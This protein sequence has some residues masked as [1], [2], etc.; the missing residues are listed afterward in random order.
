MT[1]V[2]W[3]GL[4]WGIA[5]VVVLVFYWQASLHDRRRRT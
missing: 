2:Q 4:I 5:L 3:I 1:L